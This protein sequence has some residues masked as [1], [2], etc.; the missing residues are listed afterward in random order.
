MAENV[1]NALIL[2]HLK[3][4]QSRLSTMAGRMQNL[5][6]DMRSIKGYMASFRKPK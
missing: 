2:E 4:I 3:A 5:E 1:T 6:T